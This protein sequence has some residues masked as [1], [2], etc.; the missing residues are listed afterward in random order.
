MSFFTPLGEGGKL[1]KQRPPRSYYPRRWPR[2]IGILTAAVLT[3]AAAGFGVWRL[4]GLGERDGHT[5]A[6]SCPPLR[7]ASEIPPPA[8]K[9]KINVYNA[10]PEAG[11]AA[12]VADELARRGFQV[13]GVANDPLARYV[14]EPFELR[15]G[16]KAARQLEVLAA[17]APGAVI[18]TDSKRK[19]STV[20]VVVGD[21]F[22]RL[23]N[24]DQAATV[25][26]GSLAPAGI[27]CP[28]FETA[29]PD[30]TAPS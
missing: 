4:A 12:V 3:L 24:V 9:I 19:D 14:P 29:S 10:T 30:A 16:P 15:G 22:T 25:L 8:K 1:A 7:A 13:L 21:G 11:L 18:K 23:A 6:Y 20:D 5:D 27:W 26:S 28:G 2:R 17:H